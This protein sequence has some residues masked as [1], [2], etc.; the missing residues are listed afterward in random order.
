MSLPAEVKKF[1]KNLPLPVLRSL[2]VVTHR[3]EQGPD[4]PTYE[5]AFKGKRGIEIGGPS[6]LFATQ[7]PVYQII[8]HLD[9]ANFADQTLWEGQIQEGGAYRYCRAKSGTQFVAE[10]TD[11]GQIGA[12]EYEFVISSN[13]LEHVANPLKAIGEWKRVVKEGGHLL[14]I[15]PRKEG[16]FD[17]RRPHTTM[18]HLQEDYAN[19]VLED[20]VTHLDEILQLHDLTKDKPAGTIEQFRERSSRNLSNRALHHHVFSLTLLEQ[21][22]RESGLDVVEMFQD[23]RNI[24]GLASL[25]AS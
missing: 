9:G 1:V 7:S 15:V 14:V 2:W 13:C 24:F 6:L 11:L 3:K 23:G 21:V 4:W 10:A 25:S 19:D 12:G 5:A 20:D 22:L 8:G 17:H 18:A 16:S